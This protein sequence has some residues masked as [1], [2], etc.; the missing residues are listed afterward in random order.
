MA[1]MIEDCFIFFYSIPLRYWIGT[2]AFGAKQC[3]S[4]GGR[5]A[6]AP[7]E[8]EKSIGFVSGR[9]GK[10]TGSLVSVGLLINNSTPVVY[11]SLVAYVHFLCAQGLG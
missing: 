10:H 4:R 11:G 3:R 5:A 7:A 2:F 6:R 8:D 1:L 9:V